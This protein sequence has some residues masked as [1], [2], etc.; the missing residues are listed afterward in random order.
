MIKISTSIQKLIVAEGEIETGRSW[1]LHHVRVHSQA[2]VAVTAATAALV[3]CLP[4]SLR[5]REARGI[6][7]EYARSL[8]NAQ[9]AP[10]HLCDAFANGTSC[11]GSKPHRVTTGWQCWQGSAEP[12]TPPGLWAQSL[13]R[14]TE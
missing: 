10:L 2:T 9:F 14:G 4:F 12:T 7:S 1:Q 11:S 6:I 5:Q 13:H 8:G 3:S